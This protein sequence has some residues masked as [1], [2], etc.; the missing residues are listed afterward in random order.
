MALILSMCGP[1]LPGNPAN[2][3]CADRTSGRLSCLAAGA[4]AIRAR[5][6]GIVFVIA[7]MAVAP[8]SLR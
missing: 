4:A 7:I 8:F 3:P 6:S 2:G 5:N 1:G